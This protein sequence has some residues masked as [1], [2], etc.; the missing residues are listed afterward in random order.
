MET[1]MQARRRAWA[2]A[3]GAVL[4]LSGCGGDQSLMNLRSDSAGPDEFGTLPTKPLEMPQDLA[5]L[6][7]PTLGGTNLTD[8][9]PQ[10][11]AIAALGGRP[12]VVTRG[13][14]PAA[15]GQLTRYAGRYGVQPDIRETLAIEDAE[16]RQKKRGKPLERLFNLNVYYQAYKPQSLDQHAELERWRARGTRNESAPPDPEGRY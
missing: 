7:A 4:L 13:G 14:V 15:D 3:L 12:E 6:P 8:P 2:I 10:A 9:T 16:Y 1:A 5:A 11:D